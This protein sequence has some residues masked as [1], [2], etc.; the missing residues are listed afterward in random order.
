MYRFRIVHSGSS[1]PVPD[2]LVDYFGLLVDILAVSVVDRCLD[3]AELLETE[4]Y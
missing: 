1:G 3:L 4:E 2:W